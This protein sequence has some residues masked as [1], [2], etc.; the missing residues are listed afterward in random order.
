MLS[1]TR[2]VIQ[3]RSRR[4]DSSL[5]ERYLWSLSFGHMSIEVLSSN[6]SY[7]PKT[8]VCIH[9]PHAVSTLFRA[10]LARVNCC[11]YRLASVYPSVI[12]LAQR[13]L[14]GRGQLLGTMSL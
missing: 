9:Q 10:W 6:F 14:R 13:S 1:S 8:G 7:S 4:L 5:R 2:T 11:A 12:L 3:F